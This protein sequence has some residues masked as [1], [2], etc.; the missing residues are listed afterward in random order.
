MKV[1]NIIVL[2]A[3]LTIGFINPPYSAREDG[4][5]M[6]FT[7][8]VI[9]ETLLQE[10][11]VQVTFSTANGK[12]QLL[13]TACTLYFMYIIVICVILILLYSVM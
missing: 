8:G 11:E 4:G 13:Y 6:M 9:G 1:V 10:R 12:S 2:Y 3:E 7:V 5:P